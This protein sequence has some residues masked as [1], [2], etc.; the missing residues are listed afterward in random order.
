VGV[1]ILIMAELI[2]STFLIDFI[3]LRKKK[4]KNVII[5]KILVLLK[6]KFTWKKKGHG[7]ENLAVSKSYYFE[8]VVPLGVWVALTYTLHI[9]FFSNQN[10]HT[11]SSIQHKRALPSKPSFT[12][13][14]HQFQPLPLPL[15][16][17]RR[18]STRSRR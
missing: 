7:N 11:P 9:N 14:H 16:N 17:R 18:R 5:T 12:S 8:A 10:P 2:I 3:L 13:Q 4:Q 6:K 15:R 1:Q